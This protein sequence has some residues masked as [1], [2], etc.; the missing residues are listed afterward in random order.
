MVLFEFCMFLFNLHEIKG[1]IKFYINLLALKKY[2]HLYFLK[3]T[4]INLIHIS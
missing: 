4:S 1:C 3:V 2:F